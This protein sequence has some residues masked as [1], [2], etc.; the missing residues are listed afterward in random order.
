[1]PLLHCATHPEARAEFRCDGCGKL[2][3]PDCVEEGHRLF[4]CRLCR[5]RALPLAAAAPASVPA[6]RRAAARTRPYG[7]R[8]ALGYPVRGQGGYAFWAALALLP[9]FALVRGVRVPGLG[10]LTGVFLLLVFFLFPGMLYAIAR[11]TAAGNDELPDWPDYS[12]TGDRLHE[13]LTLFGLAVVAIIPA[14]LLLR[15]GG[16]LRPELGGGWRAACWLPLAVGVIPGLALAVPAF[17]ALAVYEGG[18]VLLAR[19]D[20]H[21][22]ALRAAGADGLRTVALI[23]LF[24]VAGELLALLFHALPLL[25]GFLEAGAIVYTL[26]V[27][28]HLVG[29]MFRRH[30]PALDAV[31]MG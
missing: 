6:A 5:E 23:Y 29:W 24:L 16:C 22:R 28:A 1:M 13:L 10:L 27:G 20:L 3:C 8:D 12:E 11:H 17:G 21:F 15:L 18:W 31:Y 19:L 25:G 26:F 4:F 7:W 9:A 2:L 14:A 30:Q